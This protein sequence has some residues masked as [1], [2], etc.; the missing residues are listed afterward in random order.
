MIPDPT[1]RAADR[2]ARRER[3][4]I[5]HDTE[6]QQSHAAGGFMRTTARSLI[7]RARMTDLQ[8]EGPYISAGS[9]RPFDSVKSMFSMTLLRAPSR[10]GSSSA[11]SCVWQGGVEDK[12]STNV[13]FRRAEAARLNEHSP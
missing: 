9:I 8:D 4:D 1:L 11:T 13:V 5:G 6:H 7:G 3:G 10:T 12:H 2:R